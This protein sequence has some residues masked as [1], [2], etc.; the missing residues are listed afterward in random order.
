MEFKKSEMMPL[1]RRMMKNPFLS[2]ELLDQLRKPKVLFDSF[3]ELVRAHMVNVRKISEKKID[4]DS[5]LR[6]LKEM[7]YLGYITK[8]IKMLD[9]MVEELGY[10]K[11]N[12]LLDEC[13]TD[14]IDEEV[15]KSGPTIDDVKRK[16][17][18]IQDELGMTAEQMQKG[19]K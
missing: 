1:V 19:S 7:A 4:Q 17:K 14:W 12:L 15:K 2:T 3:E 10:F 11:E 5:G 8:R 13:V 18:E 9:K 6:G 16:L